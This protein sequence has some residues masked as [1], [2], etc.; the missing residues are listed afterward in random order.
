MCMYGK[1]CLKIVKSCL[2]LFNILLP[3]S[4]TI[5]DHVEPLH[6]SPNAHLNCYTEMLYPDVQFFLNILTNKKL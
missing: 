5:S 1:E 6:I 2:N 3:P 4:H